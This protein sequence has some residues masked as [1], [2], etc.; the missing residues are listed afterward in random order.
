MRAGTEPTWSCLE[1]VKEEDAEE[2]AAA[3]AAPAVAAVEERARIAAAPSLTDALGAATRAAAA[4]EPLEIPSPTAEPRPPPSHPALLDPPLDPAA[5]EAAEMPAAEVLKGDRAERAEGAAAKDDDNDDDDDD[6]DDDGSAAR[7]ATADAEKTWTADEEPEKKLAPFCVLGGGARD[8]AGV[9][10]APPRP[11]HPATA[12]DP[13]SPSV[14]PRAAL[15]V[16]AEAN[17]ETR[18]SPAAMAVS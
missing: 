3:A 9:T 2:E 15:T 8:A 17:S 13:T 10:A 12:P 11:S 4:A 14:R 18:R 16:A 5:K 1:E 6:D 7:P